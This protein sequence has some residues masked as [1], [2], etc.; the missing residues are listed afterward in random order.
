MTNIP[1]PSPSRYAT[2]RHSFETLNGL[3]G[4]AAFTILLWHFDW[5]AQT[6]Y[7]NAGLAVDLFF[8]LSGFVIAYAYEARLRSGWSVWRFLV[9][10]IIRFWPLYLLG[11]AIG[12]AAL[13]FGAVRGGTLWELRTL[14][15]Y[16]LWSVTLL[17]QPFHLDA[18]AFPLNTPAWS[19]SL[20]LLVNIGYA[21]VG[22]RLGNR[23]L[24]IIVA[25]S[26]VGM[27]A[28]VMLPPEWGL[29]APHWRADGFWSAVPRVTFSFT[30]GVLLHRLWIAGK[31][32]AIRVSPLVL[33]A[34]FVATLAA[35]AGGEQR[36]SELV[37][38]AIVWPVIVALGVGIEPW[39]LGRR[40]LALLADL[41]Y[42]LYATHWG[43]YLFAGVFAG[44]VDHDASFTTAAVAALAFALFADRFYDRPVRRWLT[45]VLGMRLSRAN[46]AP[47]L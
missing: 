33:V 5:P 36:V 27:M 29:R 9:V 32:P 19:L 16:T 20:E 46:A 23:A 35:A 24:A 26:L 45:R 47:P 37:V 22:F 41:S 39:R 17:P 31:L 15:F 10:R 3:R 13:T 28:V 4:V 12:L 7:W 30:L 40:S 2:P 25:V 42:P 6:G 11:S 14:L 21:A 1:P 8:L 44:F 18:A 34:L 38:V 43:F